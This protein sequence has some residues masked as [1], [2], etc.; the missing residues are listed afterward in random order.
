MGEWCFSCAV[1]GSGGVS[2]K[3][4]TQSVI[5]VWIWTNL[6]GRTLNKDDVDD[7]GAWPSAAVAAAPLAIAPDREDLL[8][9]PASRLWFCCCCSSCG[10]TLA[11]ASIMEPRLWKAIRAGRLDFSERE[12]LLPP[13]LLPLPLLLIEDEEEEAAAIA[14]LE[15]AIKFNEEDADEEATRP[16]V[17]LLHLD[18]IEEKTG[19]K[20]D[21]TPFLFD[22]SL[23][24]FFFQ[25]T[26][27][28][29][30]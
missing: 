2:F 25:S 9:A 6:C 4:N 19:S 27:C 30:P 13:P 12:E 1:V 29:G 3:I 18:A 8:F 17:P 23:V 14:A 24:G 11:S 26:I 22:S 15:D 21:Q 5:V 7:L 20:P 10:C 28:G 16:L